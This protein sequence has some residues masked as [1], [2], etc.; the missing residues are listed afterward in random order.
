MR[1]VR[2]WLV[3]RGSFQ[4]VRSLHFCQKILDFCGFS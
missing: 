1:A 4:V 2:V 3:P